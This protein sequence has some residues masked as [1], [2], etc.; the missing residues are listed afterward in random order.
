[1]PLFQFSFNRDILT[2]GVKNWVECGTSIHSTFN[3]LLIEIFWLVFIRRKRKSFIPW[4]T[5]NSLLIEI[6]WLG[7]LR[8]STTWMSSRGVS[9]NSLLIE[10]FWLVLI[11]MQLT[12]H[13]FEVTPFNSLLIEIFWLVKLRWYHGKRHLHDNLSILF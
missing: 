13:S 2:G 9:F 12:V 3:S 11:Q 7:S 8:W 6:F 5:F 4:Y 10:I 1:M